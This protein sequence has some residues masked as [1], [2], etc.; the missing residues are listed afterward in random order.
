MNTCVKIK[1]LNPDAK[2]PVHATSGS[3]GFDL[4]SLEETF[5]YPDETKKIRTGICFEIPYGFYVRIEDRS[6]LAIKGIHKVGGIIDSDYRGEV[7]V[8]L[9]NTMSSP[10]KVEKHDRI[11]QGILTPVSQ[12]GFEEVSEL[13]ATERGEG[14]FHSTGKRDE[15]E[16]IIIA[17]IANNN[18]IGKGNKLP[19][20]IAEDLK[21]FKDLTF[22]NPVIMGRA[23]YLS[24]LDYLRKP[25]DGRTNIVLSDVPIDKKEG[26]IFC[27]SIDEAI[28]EAGKHGNK[29]F[30]IGGA[31][32]YKQMIDRA[33]KL[34]ITHIHKDFEGDIYFPEINPAKWEIVKKDDKKGKNFEF[35]F[36]T[37]GR[38]KEK[39]IE[40][41]DKKGLF[42]TFEGIDGCGKSTQIRKFVEYLFGRSKHNHIVLTRNP[43]KNRNIRAILRED[44]DPLTRAEKLAELFVADRKNQVDELIVPNIERGHFV[45]SDRYKLSTIAYQAAQGLDVNSLIKRHEGFAVPDVTFV[46][47]VSAEEAG[48]RMLGEAI[49]DEHKFEKNKTFLEIVRQNYLNLKNNLPSEKIFIING[50]QSPE[51]V[52][53][54]IKEVFEREIEKQNA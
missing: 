32:V 44:E 6:G 42:I 10:Y 21:H 48:R 33:D 19:W 16:V 38:K 17:G 28:K 53:S 54:D 8:V 39:P 22:G 45:V 4:Y 23:T 15:K 31:S 1:R 40:L 2:V 51:K 29:I 18:I 52:F 47:D 20:H 14:G 7:F 36:V 5:I 34:E 30:I 50:A 11:A 46:I 9:H 41:G 49:R 3:A 35:S 24:I 12:V 13:S 37:Y 26:F 25:L 27:P 43:Y